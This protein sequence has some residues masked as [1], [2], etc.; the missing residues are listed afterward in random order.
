MR[1]AYRGP[2]TRGPFLML[3]V[4]LFLPFHAT[5]VRGDEDVDPSFGDLR[6]H[7][8][9]RFL[10]GSALFGLPVEGGEGPVSSRESVRK[11]VCVCVS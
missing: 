7:S 10:I 4:F 9:D 3:L 5:L 2:R 11:C 1:N 8:L 6:L